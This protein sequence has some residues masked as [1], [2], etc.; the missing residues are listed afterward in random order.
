MNAFTTL[1]LTSASSSARRISRS[2][3]SMFSASDASVP[4][5]LEDVLEPV[6]SES[7]IGPAAGWNPEEPR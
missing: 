2:A 3:A 1:K 6:T 4:E 5:G 7:N